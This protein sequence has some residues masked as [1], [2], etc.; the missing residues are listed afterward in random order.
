MEK[1][2]MCSK[3]LYD[4]DMV[5]KVKKIAAL[6]TDLNG[7][8]PIL[9]NTYSEF[10]IKKKQFLKDAR[11]SIENWANQIAKGQF[12]NMDFIIRG[13][14]T[15]NYNH[16]WHQ[17]TI[18]P[19][20]DK[21]KLELVKLL[22]EFYDIDWDNNKITWLYNIVDTVFIGIMGT[23]YVFTQLDIEFETICTD[24]MYTSFEKQIYLRLFLRND[25]FHLKCNSCGETGE[26][27]SDN[28]CFK[29]NFIKTF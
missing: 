14:K 18:T 9:F 7:L 3:V 22:H 13:L 1:F 23:F 10:Q 19:Q 16:Y 15:C 29:C 27:N 17:L 28:I 12:K 25:L 2:L 26:I 21:I 6:E 11:N 8:P 24:I 20:F 5:D 4:I